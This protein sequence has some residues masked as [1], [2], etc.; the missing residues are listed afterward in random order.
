MRSTMLGT[1]Q[2][3]DRILATLAAAPPVASLP[4]GCHRCLTVQRFW[5]TDCVGVAWAELGMYVYRRAIVAVYLDRRVCRLTQHDCL[6]SSDSV[7]LKNAQPT[8]GSVCI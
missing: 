3:L 1:E 2:H 4:P 7:G 6:D 5:R 8:P